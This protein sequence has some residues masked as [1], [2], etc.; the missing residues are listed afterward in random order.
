M[1]ER[2]EKLIQLEA[3]FQEMNGRAEP[4]SPQIAQLFDLNNYFYPHAKEHGRGCGGCRGR[5]FNRMREFYTQ[6]KPEI[7]AYHNS[8]TTEQ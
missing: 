4:N 7:E 6:A 2:T 1:D 8:Q 3:V 5:V